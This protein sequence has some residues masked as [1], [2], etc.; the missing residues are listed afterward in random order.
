MLFKL[1]LAF[2]L[3]C[4]YVD[5]SDPTCAAFGGPTNGNVVEVAEIIILNETQS[6]TCDV[7]FAPRG[8]TL[9]TCTAAQDGM[10][11]TWIPDLKATVCGKIFL[12]LFIYH[13]PRSCKEHRSC[14]K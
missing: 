8:P 7:G 14:N 5:V 12:F 11:A 6:I 4:M 10:S 9:T 3:Y 2:M 1:G 13:E